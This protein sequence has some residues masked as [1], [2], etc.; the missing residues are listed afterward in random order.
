MS[1]FRPTKPQ[2]AA[3]VIVVDD[4]AEEIVCDG[5][6]GAFGHPRVWYSFDS[7]DHVEC[8]YCDR[9]FVKN[10]ARARFLA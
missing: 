4:H 1:D 6:N 9:I 5:G 3:E 2:A 8:G 7:Q 10:R